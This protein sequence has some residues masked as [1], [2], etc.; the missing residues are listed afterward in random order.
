MDGKSTFRTLKVVIIS[1]S[2]VIRMNGFKNQVM[3]IQDGSYCLNS[4]AMN[5]SCAYFGT[6]FDESPIHFCIPH[7][8]VSYPANTVSYPVGFKPYLLKIK[9][10]PTLLD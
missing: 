7:S 6:A 4:R 3:T 1:S 2:S 9:S 5:S 8:I 10:Y